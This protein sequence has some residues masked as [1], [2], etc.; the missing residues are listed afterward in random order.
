MSRFIFSNE[1]KAMGLPFKTGYMPR[2]VA[3]LVNIF[4]FLAYDWTFKDE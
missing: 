1:Q 3:R 4:T 2:T